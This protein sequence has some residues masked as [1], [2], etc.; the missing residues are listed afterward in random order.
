VSVRELA[1]VGMLREHVTILDVK[2]LADAIGHE[3]QGS[4]NQGVGQYR[5]QVPRLFPKSST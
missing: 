1:F 5:G 4:L 3:G 2:G